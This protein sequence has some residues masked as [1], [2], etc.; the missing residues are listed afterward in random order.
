MAKYTATPW[1]WFKDS[2]CGKLPE[3]AQAIHSGN[4]NQI[5]TNRIY[6]KNTAE[7]EANTQLIVAA[8]NSYAKL[9]ERAIE[10]AEG[11]LLDTSQWWECARPWKLQK[12]KALE[13]R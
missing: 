3:T 7:I 8:V 2:Y 5:I 12:P 1:E 4:W 9:G 11:D 13:A 10:A 6:G